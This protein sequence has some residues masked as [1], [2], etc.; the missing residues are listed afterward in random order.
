ME[1]PSI[2][3]AVFRPPVACDLCAGVEGV[4]QVAN[5]SAREFEENFAYGLQPLVV[6]DAAKDWRAMK[7]RT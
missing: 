1:L 3:K 2:S 4:A 7:V 6:T 5:L